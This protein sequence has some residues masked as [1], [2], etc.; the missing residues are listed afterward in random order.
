M[1]GRVFAYCRVSGKESAKSNISIPGQRSSIR[2]FKREHFPDMPWYTES[3]PAKETRGF[4]ID[5]AVSAWSKMFH[6]RPAANLILQQVAPGDVVIFH[7]V[8]RGFRN[9][10]DFGNVVSSL[11]NAGITVRFAVDESV[12]FSTASGK[13]M[14]NILAT[15][16]QYSSD[17]KSERTR[18]AKLIRK[19]GLATKEELKVEKVQSVGTEWG[20][21]IYADSAK[22]TKEEPGRVFG[23]IRC[24][25]VK[26]L[27]SGLGLGAQ[28]DGVSAYMKKIMAKNSQLEDMGIFADEA[29]S[30]FSVPFDKRPLGSKIW[31]SLQKGD[32]LVVYRLDRAWR[33]IQDCANMV[34]RCIKKGI[35]VHIAIDGVS[36]NDPMGQMHFHTLS[37]VA[38]IE[39]Y[40]ISRRWK[41]TIKQLK[42]EGRRA[43][44]FF[45]ASSKVEVSHG[46]KKLVADTKAIA[47]FGNYHELMTK[48]GLNAGDVHTVLLLWKAKLTGKRTY[49]ISD[50]FPK[51]EETI[52]DRARDF[53]RLSKMLSDRG[54]KLP[55]VDGP[56]HHP[57]FESF[58]ARTCKYRGKH[59]LIRS[60]CR[61]EPLPA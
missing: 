36:S 26:S 46:K 21:A 53:P 60:I 1:E 28:E 43:V 27:E 6:E 20:K 3:F 19:L 4:F 41:E 54:A 44:N 14:G 35:H 34:D 49:M 32:H 12:N 39:S 9:V 50:E 47:T 8:D 56:Q 40:M 59:Q 45:P 57:D 25:H 11:T 52:R 2:A 33:S 61:G 7:S 58:L 37:Y 55:H 51:K 13:F 18:E 38:W 10:A 17:V 30:A 22:D 29:V 42:S 23:Y 48:Y 31:S 16:A 5:R 24:S 15:I